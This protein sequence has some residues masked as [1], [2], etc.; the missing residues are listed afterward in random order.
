MQL[1]PLRLHLLRL[2]LCG[3]LMSCLALGATGGRIV[4][5]P[6]GRSHTERFLSVGE[7]QPGDAKTSARRPGPNIWVLLL[8]ALLLAANFV[9]VP[10]FA[11]AA[12]RL[13]PMETD[14]ATAPAMRVS[15]SRATAAGSMSGAVIPAV[16]GARVPRASSRAPARP[17]R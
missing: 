6:D 3:L 13:L 16:P 8:V 10:F 12:G 5:E 14:A 17:A 1:H 2:G 7:N 11:V 9:V 4:V 15:S